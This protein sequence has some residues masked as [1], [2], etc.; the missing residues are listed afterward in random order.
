MKKLEK[1]LL[2]ILK[3][4]YG[5]PEKQ[6]TKEQNEFMS[7]VMSKN[8]DAGENIEGIIDKKALYKGINLDFPGHEVTIDLDEKDWQKTLGTISNFTESG[9]LNKPYLGSIDIDSDDWFPSQSTK[10]S[11]K[12][13]T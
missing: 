13:N 4:I 3:E 10:S 6:R 11:D 12:D 9:G 7:N 5:I 8:L 2:R 1:H